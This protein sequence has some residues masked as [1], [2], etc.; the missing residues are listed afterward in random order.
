MHEKGI[1]YLYIKTIERSHS[2]LNMYEKIQLD[3]NY[4]KALEQI[5][6][7]L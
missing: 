7:N 1:C 2:P 3:K 4:E 5:D 6:E